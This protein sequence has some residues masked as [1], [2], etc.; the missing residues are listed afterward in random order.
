MVKCSINGQA[1]FAGHSLLAGQGTG[2]AP[3]PTAPMCRSYPCFFARFTVGDVPIGKR[4]DRGRKD[5]GRDD[6]DTLTGRDH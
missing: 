4:D 1:L 5:R 3:F 6:R 2:P